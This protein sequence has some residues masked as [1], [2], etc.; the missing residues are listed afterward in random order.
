MRMARTARRE[1]PAPKRASVSTNAS[2]G[3]PDGR[4]SSSPNSARNA[5]RHGGAM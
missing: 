2:F 3:I 1:K 4:R 5:P